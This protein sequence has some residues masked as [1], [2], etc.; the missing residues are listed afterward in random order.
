MVSARLTEMVLRDERAVIPIGCFNA[1]FGVTLS[2]PSVVGRDGVLR[3][4]EPEM[5]DTER[6]AL[7]R[8]ADAIRTALSRLS[9]RE[10]QRGRA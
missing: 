3:I 9:L 4:L 2:L 10:P 8:S 5:S 6:K 7:Q 1:A